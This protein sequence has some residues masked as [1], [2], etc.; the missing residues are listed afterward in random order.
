[1]EIGIVSRYAIHLTLPSQKHN[2]QMSLF[3]GP[4]IRVFLIGRFAVE[5]AAAL[6]LGYTQ[7]CTL[8]AL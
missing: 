4:D 5:S 1:L 8:A 6:D 7:R 3:C 2:C